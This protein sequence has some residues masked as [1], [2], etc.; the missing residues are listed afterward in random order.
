[1]FDKF[2]PSRERKQESPVRVADLDKISTR[3][4]IFTLH[5]VD[6]VISPPD[7][8][9]WLE[10]VEF[11]NKLWEL[12]SKEV[13]SPEE[14]IDAYYNLISRLCPT[15][16]REDIAKANQTQ[17]SAMWQ[18]VLDM[19]NGS[20]QKKTLVNLAMQGMTKK[21]INN[22]VRILNQYSSMLPDSLQ[23]SQDSLI[24]PLT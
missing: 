19:M 8:K 4:Y 22:L 16:T 5:G 9:S 10:L 15:I 6:H 1:M 7:L 13:V 21:D 14:F 17:V 24:G 2:M 23:T 18:L 3:K 20:A 12:S 11:N